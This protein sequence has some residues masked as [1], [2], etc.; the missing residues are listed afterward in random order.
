MK[1]PTKYPTR[2]PIN[3]EINH[4]TIACQKPVS[5]LE[6]IITQQRMHPIHGIQPINAI[7]NAVT[8]T[9]LK[10][11]FVDSLKIANPIFKKIVLITIPI[12]MIMMIKIIIPTILNPKIHSHGIFPIIFDLFVCLIVFI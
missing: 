2:N 11:V 8:N 1:V 7:I 6:F 12:T 5:C 4:T 3:P 10:S 9:E